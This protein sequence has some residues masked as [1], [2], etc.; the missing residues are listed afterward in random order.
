MRPAT[1]ATTPSRTATCSS[2]SRPAP[3]PRARRLAKAHAGIARLT[4]S[5]AS[6]AATEPPPPPPPER[7]PT[8]AEYDA[9]VVGAGFGGLAAATQLAVAGAKV[10]VLER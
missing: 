7:A 4:R 10:V 8:N 1:T 9:V 2:T 6:T 5:L 3:P